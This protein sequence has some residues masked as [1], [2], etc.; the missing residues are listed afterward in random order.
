MAPVVIVVPSYIG[1]NGGGGWDQK[2]GCPKP[3]Y[4]ESESKDVNKAR[5]HPSECVCTHIGR[6]C[7]HF[8]V[9]YTE[10]RGLGSK[11]TLFLFSLKF[12]YNFVSLKLHRKNIGFVELTMSYF[13][14]SKRTAIWIGS[15]LILM[16]ICRMR[17]FVSGLWRAYPD[18]CV[19]CLL[20]VT[21][22]KVLFE[23]EKA[24]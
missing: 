23:E 24:F 8:H 6:Q 20:C 15:V 22:R 7:V 4:I 5:G 3:R 17:S 16:W 2:R 12:R 21:V 13:S 10:H 18:A 19:S 11:K 9:S 14:T 1:K